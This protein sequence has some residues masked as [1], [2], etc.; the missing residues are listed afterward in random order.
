MIAG[1]DPAIQPGPGH[2]ATVAVVGRLAITNA[3]IV[4]AAVVTGPLQARALGAAGRGDVTAI[5]VVPQIIVWLAG[6]GLTDY[7]AIQAARGA[8]LGKVAGSIGALLLAL[9]LIPLACAIPLAGLL[10]HGRSTVRLFLVLEMG[11]T[12]LALLAGLATAIAN[13]LS[14]WKRL[15]WMQASLPTVTV[16]GVSVLFAV[17]RL[18]VVTAALTLVSGQLLS[19]VPL[20]PVLPGCLPLSFSMEVVVHGIRFGVRS[21]LN[22]LSRLV[23]ASL[24]QFLMVGLVPAAVLGF[25]SL[26]V[27]IASVTTIVTA[28]LSAA[29][30]PRIAQGDSAV[31]PRA[32]RTALPLLAVTAGAIAVVTPYAVPLAYGRA[33]GAATTMVWILLVAAIPLAGTT[34]LDRVLTSSGYPGRG[35]IAQGVAVLITIPGLLLLLPVMGGEGAAVVSLAAYSCSFAIMLGFARRRFGGRIGDYL[36]PR[37]S[38]LRL[39]ARACVGIV[40]RR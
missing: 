36:V 1:D 33:F 17:N 10:A 24:D 35:A 40:R 21:W 7:V 16:V 31:G 15:I 23:N 28:A 27:T 13:G 39:L 12:P 26:A 3:A 37:A 2:R 20:L 34:I 9:S 30:L 11:L 6:L 22:D 32:L 8:D 19:I 4:F 14:Q 29:L 18:T 5:T 25:Y 38:E